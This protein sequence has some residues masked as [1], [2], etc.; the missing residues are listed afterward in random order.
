MVSWD[1]MVEE[2][3][4]SRVLDVPVG[5][6]AHE[7]LRYWGGMIIKQPNSRWLSNKSAHLL[8]WLSNKSAHL[9]VWLSNK[10]AH[11]VYV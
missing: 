4:L 6:A 10:S 7:P 2:S 8:V 1:R 9:F 11:V 3:L 5:V